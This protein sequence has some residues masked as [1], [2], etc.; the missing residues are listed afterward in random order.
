M[1]NQ[2]RRNFTNYPIA[3]NARKPQTFATPIP[4]AMY[5]SFEQLNNLNHSLATFHSPLFIV[6]DLIISVRVKIS[7]LD[8]YFFQRFLAKLEKTY[9]VGDSP[10]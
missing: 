6:L 9:I 5:T 2:F 8:G 3:G 7:A 1:K 4:V 10:Q